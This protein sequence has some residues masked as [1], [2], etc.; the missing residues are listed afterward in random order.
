[1]AGSLGGAIT[2]PAMQLIYSLLS[3][4]KNK[5]ATDEAN[6]I[7]EE[8][9]GVGTQLGIDALRGGMATYDEGSQ[10]ALN[11]MHR[12][13]AFT[14]ARTR[15][16]TGQVGDRMA[17]RTQDVM[18][19]YDTATGNYASGL[20]DFL[21]QLSGD[22]ESIL[23][24]Y[25]DRYKKAESDL[26][27]YGEQQKADVDRGFANRDAANQAR[28]KDAGFGNSTVAT[29]TGLANETE[30]S[31]EQRRLGDDL[32]RQRVGILSGLSGDTLGAKERLG[33]RKSGYQWGGLGQMFQNNA[34]RASLAQGLSGDE[35]NSL[36]QLGLFGIQNDQTMGN[37]L[38][39]FYGTNA[40]NRANMFTTGLNNLQSWFG[41]RND[42]P[43]PANNLPFSFGQS[44]VQAPSPPSMWPSIFSGA[45]PAIGQ[46]VGNLAGGL[47][48]MF[49]G[50]GGVGVDTFSPYV[51][52]PSPEVFGGLQYP[53]GM[54]PPSF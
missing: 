16:L 51:N 10:D 9:F 41:E 1:M 20:Q 26:A 27:G 37:D 33:G 52:T 40:V 31:A 36:Q 28:L 45:A 54:G 8:R 44:S 25:G 23:S 17:D 42:L 30:R 6:R 13:R 47:G 38:S 15:Q 50:G 32:V 14:N 2:A 24:G 18:G 4:F 43:P 5:R 12:N 11:A 3:G 7:N 22:D 29:S 19:Q 35:I 48:N 53:G 46:G 39:N 49:G 21:R 34:G